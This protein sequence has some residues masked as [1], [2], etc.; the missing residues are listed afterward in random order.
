MALH[1][2]ITGNIGSGKSTVCR[3]FEILGIPVYYA[4]IRAKELLNTDSEIISKVKQLLG[5]DVYDLNNK[6]NRKKVAELV[7]ANPELLKKYNAIIHPAVL[8]DGSSWMQQFEE[9]P[10]TLKEA[11]LLFESGAYQQLDKIICVTAPEKIRITRVQKRDNVSENEVLQ[12]MQNQWSEEKKTAASDYI[13]T[14]DGTSLLIPQVMEIHTQ[15]L[16]LSHQ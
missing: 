12:R 3:L 13:I 14:N 10:Y 4:D 11:A 1:V 7:F 6:L 5:A 9:K 16:K 2:G 8:Q 15:L